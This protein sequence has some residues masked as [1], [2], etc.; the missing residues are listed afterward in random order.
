M[1][2]KC[3]NSAGTIRFI[4]IHENN[5]NLYFNTQKQMN[6]EYNKT[7]ISTS[8]IVRLPK[9]PQKQKSYLSGGLRKRGVEKRP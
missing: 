4:S 7:I 5:S 6:Y 1:V 3:T 8:W 9:I 2:S